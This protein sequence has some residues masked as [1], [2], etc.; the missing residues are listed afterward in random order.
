MEERT[1][2]YFV[3]YHSHMTDTCYIDVNLQ[4]AF[5]FLTLNFCFTVLVGRNTFVVLQ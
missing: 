2:E 1:T 4:T 5:E 3:N